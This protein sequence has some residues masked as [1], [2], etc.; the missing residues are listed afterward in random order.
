MTSIPS[1]CKICQ[2]KFPSRSRLFAHLRAD[3]EPE[4]DAC[5]GGGANHS[6][7]PASTLSPNQRQEASTLA[8][9]A[10]TN[11]DFEA[12]YAIQSS[13]GEGGTGIMSET[14]WTEALRCFRTALPLSFR[15]NCHSFRSDSIQQHLLDSL[16]DAVPPGALSAVR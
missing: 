6:T 8:R 16:F 4:P 1:Q 11:A 5:G 13:R 10:L 9:S 7:G 2:A 15:I 12:Y 3:H 14:E